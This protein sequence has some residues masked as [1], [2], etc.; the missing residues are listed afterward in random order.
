VW[1]VLFRVHFKDVIKWEVAQ[2]SYERSLPRSKSDQGGLRNH[3]CVDWM[4]YKEFYFLFASSW[5]GWSIAGKC[6]DAGESRRQS[7]RCGTLLK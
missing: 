7:T 5:I 4:S 2:E 3:K 6:S 1:R